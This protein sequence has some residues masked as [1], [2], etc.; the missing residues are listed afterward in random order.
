MAILWL[1]RGIDARVYDA[2][3]AQ[4]KLGWVP[5][6]SPLEMLAMRDAESGEMLLPNVRMA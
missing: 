1:H 2:G 4:R 5:R 3:G 6:Y